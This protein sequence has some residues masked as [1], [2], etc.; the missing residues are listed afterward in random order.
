MKG[1]AAVSSKNVCLQLVDNHKQLLNHGVV[2]LFSSPHPRRRQ[3][4][5]CTDSNPL[6]FHD[7]T[8]VSSCN[9]RYFCLVLCSCF[10]RAVN[11]MSSKLFL[12]H[13][14]PDFCIGEFF[15]QC[16]T[17]HKRYKIGCRFEEESVGRAG[18]PRICD[19]IRGED[20]KQASRAKAAGDSFIFALS[21]LYIQSSLHSLAIVQFPILFSAKNVNKM[22]YPEFCSSRRMTNCTAS[23]PTRSLLVIC[24]RSAVWLL[25]CSCRLFGLLHIM[26]A[27]CWNDTSWSDNFVRP[28]LE[29]FHCELYFCWFVAVWVDF[30]SRLIKILHLLFL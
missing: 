14:W 13:H 2:Q 28:M 4:P 16:H 17:S 20:D 15:F 6:P 18:T 3:P 9:E 21:C 23:I 22:I 5:P 24:R 30:I 19:W 26:M 8:Q 12:G 1:K 10:K 29:N 7:L 11:W 25:N 27:T